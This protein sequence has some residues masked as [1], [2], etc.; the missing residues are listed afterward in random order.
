MDPF[1]GHG[2]VPYVCSTMNRDYLGVEIS[3]EI[4]NEDF[5]SFISGNEFI[6]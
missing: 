2:V 3:S 6:G 5:N 1:A 4:Y